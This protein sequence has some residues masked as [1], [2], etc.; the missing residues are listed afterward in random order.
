MN[1]EPL[2]IRHGFPVRV[3]VPGVSGCRSVKWLDQI[4]VQL[5]ESTNLYQKYDYK[6]LPPEATD[7]KAAESYWDVTPAL[8]D[9]PINS[10]SSC[11]LTLAC[12]DLLR[13][14]RII[15]RARDSPP[16]QLL[17][18]LQRSDARNIT[19]RKG[20]ADFDTRFRSLLC[21]RRGVPSHWARMR[22]S[23]LWDT[24]YLNQIRDL[25]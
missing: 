23:R 14:I 19:H 11:Q 3:I 6:R 22:Q 12:S 9:M 20:N 10:V 2:P 16:L 17:V 5:E 13:A 1:G 25:S 7:A 8:M 24:H 18:T 4:S 21:L 15:S